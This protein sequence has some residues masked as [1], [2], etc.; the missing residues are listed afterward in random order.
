MVRGADFSAS[1]LMSE[2]CEAFRMAVWAALSVDWI[3]FAQDRQ[4]L[5][6]LKKGGSCTNCPTQV[7]CRTN[8]LWRL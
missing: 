7:L 6:Q 8:R 2:S 4:Y 1:K 5:A 3:I